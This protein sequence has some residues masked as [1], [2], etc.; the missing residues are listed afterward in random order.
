MA[1][2]PRTPGSQA[3]TQVGIS[4]DFQVVHV[5]RCVKRPS[6]RATL[7]SRIKDKNVLIKVNA[8]NCQLPN[9]SCLQKSVADDC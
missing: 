5:A 1:P 9:L 7:F 2:A 3:G 8:N 4:D 6:S